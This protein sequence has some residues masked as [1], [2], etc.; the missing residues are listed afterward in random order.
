MIAKK[1]KNEKQKQ[2]LKLNY[3]CLKQS[4]KCDDEDDEMLLIIGNRKHILQFQESIRN[5]VL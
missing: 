5:H 2:Q 1:K 3:D 4:F